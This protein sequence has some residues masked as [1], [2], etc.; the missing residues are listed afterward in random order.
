MKNDD[1]TKKIVAI[2]NYRDAASKVLFQVVRYEGKDFRQRR[3]DGQGGWI[4]N[5]DN[6]KRVPYRLPELLQASKQDWIIVCEGEKD[7]DRLIA[8]GLSATCSP[9]GALRW[10]D[11]YNEYFHGRL[12][13]VI[14]DNDVR[15]KEHATQVANSLHG[16]ASEIRIVELSGLSEKE[17]VSDWLDA[18]HQSPELLELIDKAKPFEPSRL[19]ADEPQSPWELP[20]PLGQCLSCQLPV[21]RW[22]SELLFMSRQT[23]GSLLICLQLLPCRRQIVKAEYFGQ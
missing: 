1:F 3:P 20:A 7:V 21:L 19:S 4:W 13:V 9:G 10:S 16:T 5:L 12:V 2:Y 11:D 17:D 14:P 23:I 15:G 6:V 22:Q 18:G 8:Q